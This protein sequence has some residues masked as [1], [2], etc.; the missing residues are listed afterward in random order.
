MGKIT[1]GLQ[2][3]G[4]NTIAPFFK[5]HH[6]KFGSVICGEI[7]NENHQISENM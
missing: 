4:K 2:S 5:D 1:I 7:P 6:N 3:K